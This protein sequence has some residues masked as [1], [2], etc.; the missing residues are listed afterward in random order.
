MIDLA[1]RILGP[2]AIAGA[3]FVFGCSHGEA[4][5][6]RKWDAQLK[7][8]AEQQAEIERVKNRANAGVTNDY[9]E[10]AKRATVAA[11]SARSESQRLRDAL[12]NRA[13]NPEAGPAVDEGAATARALGECSE[14][15]STVAGVADELSAQVTGL[16]AYIS[17]VC[18][19][20]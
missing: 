6:K 16:Q 17:R 14:R 15:Y 7:A 11:A 1:I 13:G 12:A 20:N 19:P 18:E 4:N 2:L 5:I 9:I 8:A 10:Q 3:L